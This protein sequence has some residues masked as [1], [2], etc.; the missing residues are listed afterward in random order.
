MKKHD[1]VKATETYLGS[2]SN[3]MLDMFKKEFTLLKERKE[4]MKKQL[5]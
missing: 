4:S 1:D 2:Q 3:M 5:Q